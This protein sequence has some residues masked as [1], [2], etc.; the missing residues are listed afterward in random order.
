MVHLLDLKNNVPLKSGLCKG[1]KHYKNHW[2][3][4]DLTRKIIR[5]YDQK[6]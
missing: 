5:I 2:V 4:L 1:S 6:G 3:F